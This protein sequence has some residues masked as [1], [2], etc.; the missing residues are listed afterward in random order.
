[1]QRQ[2]QQYLDDSWWDNL[3]KSGD[4]I[5]TQ[6]ALGY[7]VMYQDNLFHA[8]EKTN[9]TLIGNDQE[10]QS[11]ILLDNGFKYVDGETIY[12]GQGFHIWYKKGRLISQIGNMLEMTYQYTGDLPKLLTK[13]L[14]LR[15][16][17]CVCVDSIQITNGLILINDYMENHGEF[18]E[19]WNMSMFNEMVY[20]SVIELFQ[21]IYQKH[22]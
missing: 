9:D 18:V 21:Y 20:E 1:M 14:S 11:K 3:Q 16:F 17:D 6:T 12:N 13:S 4:L 22:L 10:C 7:V 5:D 2:L 8:L 19:P 15:S